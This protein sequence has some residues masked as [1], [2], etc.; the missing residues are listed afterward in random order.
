MNMLRQWVWSFRFSCK[1]LFL[2]SLL[3]HCYLGEEREPKPKPPPPQALERLAISLSDYGWVWARERVLVLTLHDNLGK[4]S[5]YGEILAEKITT[6]LVKRDRFRV[7]DR[8]THTKKLEEAGLS[9]DISVDPT[10]LRKL[11]EVLQLSYVIIGIVTP[12][13]EGAF[14]NVRLV[15]IPS[16]LILRADEVFIRLD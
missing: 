13:Q 11:G 8:L 6:E 16:G 3:L 15:E 1:V 2:S 7:L 4:K 5:P 12:F 9:L 14:V 10:T